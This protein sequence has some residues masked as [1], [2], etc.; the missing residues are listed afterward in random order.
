MS[1]RKQNV[2]HSFFKIITTMPRFYVMGFNNS[3]LEYV[4]L[5]S[6]TR[7]RLLYNDVYNFYILIK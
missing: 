2:L 3:V 1:M 5:S 4:L 6:E 7:N